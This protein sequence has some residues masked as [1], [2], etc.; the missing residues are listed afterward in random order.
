[1]MNLSVDG[2]TNR[3]TTAGF[4]YD[5]AGNLTQM[6]YSSSSQTLDYDAFGRVTTVT[7]SDGVQTYF[8]NWRGQRTR[9]TKNGQTDHFFYLPDGRLLGRYRQV[10]G[11]ICD[12]ATN[13]QYASQVWLEQELFFYFGGQLV[14]KRGVMGS[15]LMR[16]TRDRLGSVGDGSAHHPYGE[17][18]TAAANDQFKFATYW[19]DGQSGLDYAQQRYHAPGLGRFTSVDPEDGSADP[20]KPGSWN[21]YSLTLGDPVNFIDPS[22][23]IAAVPPDCRAEYFMS[24]G[25]PQVKLICTA[26]SFAPKYVYGPGGMP[27]SVFSQHRPPVPT[28]PPSGTPTGGSSSALTRDQWMRKCIG[29]FYASG[30]GQITALFSPIALMP[31]WNPG[32]EHSVESWLEAVTGKFVGLYGTGVLGDEMTIQTLRGSISLVTRAQSIASWALRGLGR[33]SLAITVAATAVDIAAHGFCAVAADQRR[34]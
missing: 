9:V 4:A 11:F 21:R 19:R 29:D 2:L 10:D 28:G 14:A 31:G 15:A 5:V 20:L 3:I 27:G 32:W 23:G 7:N 24:S 8:Y 26:P 18:R 12:A 16:V 1:M 25:G 30:V 22:G 34:P 13:S 33:A 6:P 17:D